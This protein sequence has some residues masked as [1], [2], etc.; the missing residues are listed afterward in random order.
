MEPEIGLSVKV[1]DESMIDVSKQPAVTVK[2]E[3]F[4]DDTTE[5]LIKVSK[6]ENLL[7]TERSK[8]TKYLLEV[9][10]LSK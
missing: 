10:F 9:G 4:S 5:R 8:C 1:K 3:H 7:L 2:T 6:H